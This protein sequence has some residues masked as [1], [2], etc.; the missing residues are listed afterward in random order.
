MR[1][2]SNLAQTFKHHKLQGVQLENAQT[3]L[4]RVT[5]CPGADVSGKV[6]LLFCYLVPLD[7]RHRIVIHKIIAFFILSFRFPSN[8]HQAQNKF[9][10]ATV[11]DTM[12]PH[13]MVCLLTFRS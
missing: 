6:I 7:F 9:K 3:T 2:V 1:Y 13:Q 5:G 11:G 8:S 4:K 12:N 10:T